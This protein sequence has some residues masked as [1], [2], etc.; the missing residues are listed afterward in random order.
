[1]AL[2]ILDARAARWSAPLRGLYLFMRWS[3]AG[4][5]AYMLVGHFVLTWGWFAG[6]WFFI[7]PLLH[8]LAQGL[9]ALPPPEA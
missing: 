3:L 2:E 1:M 5:G 9:R 4:I 7:A 8:G 6:L